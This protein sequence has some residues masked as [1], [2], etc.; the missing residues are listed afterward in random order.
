MHVVEVLAQLGGVASRRALVEA[1]SRAQ[2]DRAL[3][4]GDIVA[5]ARGRYALPAADEALRAANRLHAVASHLSAALLWGWEVK[6][7]PARPHVTVGRRR[8][9]EPRQRRGVVLHWADLSPDEVSGLLTSKR[10]TL[11]DC[12]RSLPFDE[13][14][15]VADS[16]LRHEDETDSGLLALARTV[17]GPGARAVRRVAALASGLAAN[18]FESGLRAIAEQVPGLNVRPQVP[19]GDP[20]LLGTPDLVDA[21]LGIVLEADSF[22]W[23]G[24]RRALRRDTRRYDSFVVAGWLVLRF[25]YEDVMGDPE[26]VAEI[27]TA[28]VRRRTQGGGCPRCAA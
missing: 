28:A 7:P 16:A 15:T 23:H 17:R 12:L 10:R 27:L 11:T 9:L 26:W 6:G 20:V 25:S 13:G 22:A 24:D 14:L 1:T 5:D 8:R 18:P 19:I 21:D 3:A 2:V 4:T